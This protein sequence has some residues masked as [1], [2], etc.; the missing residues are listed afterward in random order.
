DDA[1]RTRFFEF[2][3][4][5]D[6]DLAAD[7]LEHFDDGHAAEMVAEKN[8]PAADFPRQGADGKYAE[9]VVLDFDYWALIPR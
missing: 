1:D 6:A 2:L 4:A 9:G 7:L 8:R 5:A 3:T